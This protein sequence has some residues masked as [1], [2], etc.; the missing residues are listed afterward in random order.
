MKCGQHYQRLWRTSEKMSSPK[1]LI[2]GF[3]EWT[4]VLK[5]EESILNNYNNAFYY[6]AVFESR[7]KTYR[8]PLVL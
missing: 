6:N 1:L 7:L 8:A 4:S 2:V 5:L 3:A